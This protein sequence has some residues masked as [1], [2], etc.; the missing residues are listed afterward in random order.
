MGRIALLSEGRINILEPEADSIFVRPLTCMVAEKYRSRIR[1]INLRKEWKQSGTGAQFAGT[2]QPDASAF[3]IRTPITGLSKGLDKRLI[4]S[5]N[6]EAGGGIYFKHPN[7]ED[8]ET[9][10]RADASVRF[11]ELDVNSSGCIAVSCAENHFERHIALI[12]SD[13]NS[14]QVITEGECSDCNPKWSLKDEKLLYYDSAGFGYGSA[15]QMTGLGPRSIYRI[16][17]KTGELDE[18]LPGDKYEYSHPF[19]DKDG[20]LYYIRR[21][22]KQSKGGMRVI[23]YLTA[24]FKILRAIGGWLDFFS[25]RYTGESLKT[26]GANPAIANTKSPQQ[27]FIDGNLLEAEK[28]L[29][30]NANDKNPGYVPRDWELVVMR[31]GDKEKVL[32]TSVM[33]YCVTCEGVIYSN[34]QYIIMGDNAVKVH[35]AQNLC[36][37]S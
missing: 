31:P 10:I 17:T 34:G 19:E 33:S 14:Y 16:N 27:I 22:Y 37:I 15:G 28:N 30:Q 26:S 5:I 24:P 11:Y 32:C 23:D 1:E 20:S 21:P 6:Y 12:K 18:V 7:N 13:D 9:H 35:L 25:R 29:R 4:Y 36:L 8:L 2:Y 3:D